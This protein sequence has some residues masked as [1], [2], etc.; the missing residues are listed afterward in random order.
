MSD[1]AAQWLSSFAAIT[2]LRKAEIVDPVGTLTQLAEARQ[3]R[4]RA[5][6]G[7]FNF[8][9]AEQDFPQEPQSDRGLAAWPDIP[10][11]FW[12]WVNAGTRGTE[13]YGD[14]GVYAATVVYDPDIGDYSETEHIKLFGVTFHADDLAAFLGGTTSFHE[15]PLLPGRAKSPAGRKPE[16]DRWAD[17]GAALALIAH[18][19]GPD[20]LKSANALYE[21]A[22]GALSASGR[23]PLSKK[24]V[25]RM[26]NH[27][28]IWLEGGIIQE[29]PQGRN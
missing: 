11:D 24:T 10:A 4:S 22:S 17:F 13:V 27:A 20:D 6:W 9:D 23:N 21:A 26:I 3:L 18:T 7:R 1:M 28:H 8:E 12:R 16:L 2:M 29:L 14:A 19:A 15:T 25:S 5:A